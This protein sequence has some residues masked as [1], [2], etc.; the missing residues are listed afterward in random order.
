MKVRMN[1]KYSSLLWTLSILVLNS[2]NSFSATMPGGRDRGEVDFVHQH[3]HSQSPKTG[4]RCEEVTIPMCKDMPYNQTILPNL[5]GHATQ[6]E[7]G[8]EV[9]QYYA[10]VKVCNN[11]IVILCRKKQKRFLLH[12]KPS[13]QILGQGIK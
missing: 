13:C 8:Y 11:K 7:A 2:V 9:H 5:M 1:T 4:A 10:L 12:A 6:E 3:D